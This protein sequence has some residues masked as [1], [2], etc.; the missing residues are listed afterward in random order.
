MIIQQSNS[1]TTTVGSRTSGIFGNERLTGNRSTRREAILQRIIQSKEVELHIRKRE[2]ELVSKLKTQINEISS[3]AMDKEIRSR[4]ISGIFQ[5]ISD[6]MNGRAEREKALMELEATLKKAVIEDAT[7]PDERRTNEDE[8]HK[9]KEEAEESKRQ[10]NIK[11]LTS[12]AIQKDSISQ[13]SRTR[14][15]LSSK[16]S[17]LNQ[18]LSSENRNYVKIGFAPSAD[19]TVHV[20]TGFGNDDWENNQLTKLNRGIAGINAAKQMAISNMYQESSKLQESQL[21]ENRTMHEKMDGSKD[22]KH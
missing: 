6:I 1:S 2:D 10:N 14:A 8:Q 16:A 19:I 18:A 11:N 13:L 21:A 7:T 17:Q 4:I 12:I 3:S 9:T 15:V 22:D 5:Q 20:Q